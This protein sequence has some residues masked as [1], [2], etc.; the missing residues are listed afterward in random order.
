MAAL[1]TDRILYAIRNSRSAYDLLGDLAGW[2]LLPEYRKQIGVVTENS[3]RARF[4]PIAF[5]KATS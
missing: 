1:I 5:Q 3:I 4:G 2:L